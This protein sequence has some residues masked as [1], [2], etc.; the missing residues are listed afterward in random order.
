[1]TRDGHSPDHGHVPPD[2]G[3]DVDVDAAI[4]RFEDVLFGLPLDRVLPDIDELLSRA[5]LPRT[6]LASD[7]RALK[8]LHEAVIARPWAT[9]DQRDQVR[10]QVALLELEVEVLVERLDDDAVEPDVVRATSG[11]IRAIRDQL[12]DLRR[13]L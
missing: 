3:H 6:L 8:L 11:R 9:P 13:V 5:K 2:D 10:S 1:M 4:A 7:D 12:D